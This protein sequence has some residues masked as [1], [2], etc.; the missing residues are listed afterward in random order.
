M[1]VSV[2]SFNLIKLQLSAYNVLQANHISLSCSTNNKQWHKR[3]IHVNGTINPIYLYHL[4]QFE[5]NNQVVIGL[6]E[7]LSDQD[8]WQ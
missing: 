1:Y 2:R 7:N 3:I 8:F 5:H 4:N 6:F